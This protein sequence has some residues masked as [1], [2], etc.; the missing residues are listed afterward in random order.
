L[1]RSNATTRKTISL[2]LAF[3]LIVGTI[4]AFYPSP[5]FMTEAHAALSA[6]EYNIIGTY[7]KSY[8]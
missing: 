4:A 5:S 7:K 8:Q 6:D 1:N 3:M 2:F